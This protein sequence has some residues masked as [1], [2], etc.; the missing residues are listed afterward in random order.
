MIRK[1]KFNDIF[2]IEKLINI[3]ARDGKVLKRQAEEIAEVINSFFVY[4]FNDLVVGCISLEVYSP[5]LAEIRSL[6]VLPEFQGKGIA[7][8]LIKKCLNEAKIKDVYE[9]LTI[10]DKLKLF[11]SLDFKKQ[12]DDQWPL[13]I[14][15]KE[16]N[17]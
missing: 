8:K 15:L 3:G 16:R 5:K 13:F 9:L 7:T 10:T 4:T 12:L 14:R 1:A 11:E 6:V 2:E 17:K